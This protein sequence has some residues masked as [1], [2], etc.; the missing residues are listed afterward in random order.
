LSREKQAGTTTLEAVLVFPVL[1]L[2]ITFI[3]Q[4][5]LWYHAAGLATAA[6]QDGA[7][8]ARVQGATAADGISRANQVL[9]Q[10]GPTILVGRQVTATRA[11]VTRVE[12]RGHCIEL[13]PF[14]SL[15]VHA[16]AESSTEEFKAGRAP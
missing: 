11:D 10:T 15:P 7:R 4:V 2:L 12:V 13:V 1:L 16:V 8:A 6:A 5:A 3:I 9:D 14:M